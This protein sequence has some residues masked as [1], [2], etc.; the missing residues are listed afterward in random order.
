ML[1]FTKLT[2]ETKCFLESCMNVNHNSHNFKGQEG[3][4]QSQFS[5]LS[6]TE[7]LRFNVTTFF[8]NRV[9]N[10]NKL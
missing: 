4:T 7:I 2:N 10:I 8:L 3:F 5:C 9:L 1:S 6:R